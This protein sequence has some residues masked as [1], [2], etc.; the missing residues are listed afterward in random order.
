MFV[1]VFVCVGPVL[2]SLGLERRRRC[3]SLIHQHIWT[4]G[5][6]LNI[7]LVTSIDR[8]VGTYYIHRQSIGIRRRSSSCSSKWALCTECNSCRQRRVERKEMMA[9]RTNTQNEEDV[10]EGSQRT[11]KKKALLFP[12]PSEQVREKGWANDPHVQ[13]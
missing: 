5:G 13:T 2:F 1:S 3:G 11:K 7:L 6:R 9:G 8:R 4:G 10:C 12:S